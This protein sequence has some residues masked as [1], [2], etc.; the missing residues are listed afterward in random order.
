MEGAA[1]R[2]AGVEADAQG[3]RSGFSTALNIGM[4][5]KNVEQLYNQHI[6]D[7]KSPAEAFTLAVAQTVG[8]DIASATGRVNAMGAG[9]LL[10]G[11]LANLTP[12]KAV[13]SYIGTGY[14]TLVALSR[15]AGE[16]AA[17]GRLDT[18]TLD[19][20]AEAVAN[21]PDADPFA[22]YG[23]IGRLIGEESARTD[24]GNLWSDLQHISSTGAGEEVLHESMAE[25]QQQAESGAFGSPLQG[26]NYLTQA[27]AEVVADPGTT[28]GQFFSD[29][30]NMYNYGVG[31]GFWD[32][33]LN[34]T[35]AVIDKT[36][37]ANVIY[38]GYHQVFSG[39]ADQGLGAFTSEMAEGASALASEAYRASADAITDA[40]GATYNYIRSWF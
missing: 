28:I 2:P 19:N 37:V 17:A 15:T 36:P 27:A 6:A 12:E 4:D 5:V 39:I 31:D 18:T 14:D 35:V 26:I 3:A 34:H 11:G 23:Q 24:G 20:F 22:G 8:G 1:S 13:E 7:G 40:A 32:E 9:A 30:K 33:A 38:D 16:S 29:V 21:K 25:F 10:P